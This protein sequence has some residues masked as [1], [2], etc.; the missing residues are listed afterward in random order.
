MG[1]VTLK[2]KDNKFEMTDKGMPTGGS[3]RYQGGGIVLQTES[4]MGLPISRSPG[5]GKAHPDITVTPQRDGTLLLSDPM[6]IDGK[7]VQLERQ[8]L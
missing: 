1:R 6:A 5:A 8:K 3:I 4:L 7:Q 2:I